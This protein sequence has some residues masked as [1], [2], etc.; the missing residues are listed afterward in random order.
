MTKTTRG[1]LLVLLS[2]ASFGFMPVLAKLAYA[3]GVNPLTLLTLRFSIAAVAMW[4]IWAYQHRGG[5]RAHFS[6]RR[7][8]ALILLG[9]VGYVGQ[10]F[11]YFTAASIISASATALLLYI[12][13]VLVTLL[14]WI[15][16]HDRLTTRKMLSLALAIIGTLMVLGIASSLLT[17]GTL[18]LGELRADGVSWAVAAAV[19]YSL[20]IIAGARFTPGIPPVFSSAVII[21][22][23][24]LV[25]ATW[26]SVSGAL[27]L[28][29]TTLGWLYAIAI[30]LVPT[31]IAI[32]LFFVGLDIIGPSRAAIVSTAEPTVSV[33]A[34]GIILGEAIT[35]EQALGGVLILAAVVVLE[36]GARQSSAK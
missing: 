12:Y 10:S 36:V 20:Y 11:S 9:G 5:R 2:A 30:A 6:R 21:S 17:T 15:F 18:G 33:L 8:V 13:P 25:Y 1:L 34:A 22:A 14:A 16:F 4:L 23:A 26:S 3:Q 27:N 35:V 28:N 29:I 31:V 32:T 19:I 7:L 24:A